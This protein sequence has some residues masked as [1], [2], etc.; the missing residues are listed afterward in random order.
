LTQKLAHRR[1]HY[2]KVVDN[3]LIAKKAKKWAILAA[4]PEVTLTLCLNFYASAGN[5][6]HILH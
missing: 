4:I 6:V 2:E 3:Q 5:G 1:T